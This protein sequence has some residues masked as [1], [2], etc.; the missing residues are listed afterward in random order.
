M[1]PRAPGT[2]RS[3]IVRFESLVGIQNLTSLTSLTIKDRSVTDLSALSG[4]TSLTEL[5]LDKVYLE[6]YGRTG[7]QGVLNVY[8]S[9]GIS[10]PEQQLFA[11]RTI[12]Q[13][14]LFIASDWGP[15][16]NAGALERMQNEACTDMRA[17]HMGDGAGH[18]VELEQPEETSRPLIEFLRD[19]A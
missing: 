9:G 19:V 7:F 1:E 18:W 14:S 3:P 16:Q 11:G 12:D 5:A 13:P 15:Y 17:V 4:L 8:R 2:G 6:E 10:A